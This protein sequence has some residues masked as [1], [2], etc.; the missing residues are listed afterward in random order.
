MMKK[1]CLK[2]LSRYI[3]QKDTP[4][5]ILEI[6]CGNGWLSAKLARVTTGMVVGID[7]SAKGI[8]QAKR[9]FGCIP[10][11]TFMLTDFR[12]DCLAREKFDLVVISASIEYFSSFAELINMALNKLTLMGEIHIIASRLYRQKEIVGARKKQ[13]AGFASLGVPSMSR[14]YFLHT[15]EDL[16]SYHFKILFDPNHWMN[17]LIPGSSNL[18]HILIKNHY[19]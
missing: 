17:K 3:A 18:H 15:L 7:I 5:N 16:A 1:Q 8:A 13:R 9:V 2:R 11:L 4:V 10:N 12:K 6:G 14:Y 19:H